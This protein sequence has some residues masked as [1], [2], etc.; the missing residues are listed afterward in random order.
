MTRL[1]IKADDSF[2][3][4]GQLIGADIEFSS[5]KIIRLI[6]K[7]GSGKSSFIQ[8]LKLNKRKY[9][10]DESLVF[11]DQERLNPLNELS[12]K[13]LCSVLR[14]RNNDTSEL[15]IKLKEIMDPFF[16]KPIKSLSGG[17]NQLVKLY[18]GLFLSGDFFI[19][20][21]PFQYLDESNQN[22]LMDILKKLKALGK[23]IL[24]IEHQVDLSMIVDQEV[25]LKKL[26]G[27]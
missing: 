19:F 23:K 12:T 18:S 20:D 4:N 7:N 3:V 24:V 1:N 13:D 2:F 14:S 9:F 15:T 17:Q 10:K 16:E 5:G 8:F 25:S 26:G 6:G 21:E 22:L 27:L 11:I